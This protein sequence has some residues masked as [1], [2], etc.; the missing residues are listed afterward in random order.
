MSKLGELGAFLKL[1]GRRP[2]RIWVGVLSAPAMAIS[3]FGFFATLKLEDF[4]MSLMLWFAFFLSFFHF[5]FALRIG[6]TTTQVR[7]LDYWYLGTA[8]VGLFFFAAA[9]QEQREIYTTRFN[10]LNRIGRI[11]SFEQGLRRYEEDACKTVPP[12]PDHCDTVVKSLTLLN[13]E[14]VSAAVIAAIRDN[15]RT[16]LGPENMEEK[17]QVDIV[18]PNLRQGDPRPPVHR[19]ILEMHGRFVLLD[20]EELLNWLTTRPEFKPKAIATNTYEW[21]D[22]AL[23]F[24]QTVIWPFILAAALALRLTKVTIEVLAWPEN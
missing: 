4:T 15:L 24:G 9:Y 7:I 1:M 3:A 12:T 22:V 13:Q 21:R 23:G 6:L 2:S 19:K 5:G 8:A 16:F 18:E 10:E 11:D 14:A 20:A 17:M